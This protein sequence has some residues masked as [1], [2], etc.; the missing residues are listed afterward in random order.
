[1]YR[2]LCIT[3]GEY[4][5][6]QPFGSYSF[7]YKMPE[8]IQKEVKNSV[9]DSSWQYVEFTTESAAK[10]FLSHRLVYNPVRKDARKLQLMTELFKYNGIFGFETAKFEFEVINV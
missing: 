8:E 10:W 9:F 5:K 4:I 6:V 7:Y 1:M 3:T 2:I